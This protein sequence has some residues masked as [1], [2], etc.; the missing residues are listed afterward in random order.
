MSYQ[1]SALAA[2]VAAQINA[3]AGGWSATVGWAPDLSTVD[4]RT[5]FVWLQEIR[6]A[7]VSTASRTRYEGVLIVA[8]LFRGAYGAVGADAALDDQ[9]VLGDCLTALPRNSASGHLLR[10]ETDG[11]QWAQPAD[12]LLVGTWRCR[13]EWYTP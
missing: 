11:A 6:P 4:T 10:C 5:C 1:P 2:F 13:V 3:L 7:M 8:A 12:G 9:K